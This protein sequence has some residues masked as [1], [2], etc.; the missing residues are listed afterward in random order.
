MVARVL[1]LVLAAGLFAAS[2]MA[3]QAVTPAGADAS[4]NGGSLAWTLGQVDAAFLNSSAGS[5]AQ[6]VQHPVELLTVAVEEQGQTP[7][8]SAWP[9]PTADALTID[10]G[11]AFDANTQYQVLDAAGNLIAEGRV[12]ASPFTISFLDRPAAS[13]FIRILHPDGT[14]SL[15]PVIK[16]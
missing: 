4:G 10:F 3:Q 7:G 14:S 9:N 5:M 2:A 16:H 11:E 6:G 1:N 13:Y 8:L 12:N 15:L